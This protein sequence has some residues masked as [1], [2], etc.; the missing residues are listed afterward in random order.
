MEQTKKRYHVHYGP[1]NTWSKI[2][3]Q[4][5]WRYKDLIW[6]FVKRDFTVMY[7]QT[8]LGPLWIL[9]NP[10]LSTAMYSVMFGTIANLPT[11]GAPRPLFYL[12]G[13]ALWTF[14]SSSLT[15]VSGTFTSNSG[16]FSKVYFPRLAMPISTMLSALINFCVQF[17]LVF[18]LMLFYTAQ[19]LVHPRVA[20]MPLLPLILLPVGLLGLGC[21]VI[22]SSVTTRYRD[23]MVVVGFGVQLWMYGT[24]VVYPMSMLDSISPVLRLV[25]VIN[26]MTA[27]METFRYI[28]LGAA[29]LDMLPWVSTII[30]TA[31]LL[32]GGLMLF[33]KVEKNFIDTV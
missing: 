19:G 17:M 8:I 5:L 10:L 9:I 12:A 33:N 18:L 22:V 14:F 7:K 32:Y 21:G 16:M 25:M 1:S 29:S 6:L 11:D 4:E 15:R 30:W 23:L 13:T 27:P 28:F 31:V 2:D 26:P 24:P 3:F 20:L